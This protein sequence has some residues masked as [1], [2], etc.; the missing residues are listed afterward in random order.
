LVT[1]A[2][3][4]G[5]DALSASQFLLWLFRCLHLASES[6]FVEQRNMLWGSNA[7]YLQDN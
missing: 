1:V 7:V 2:A 5:G 6:G 4:F 3:A